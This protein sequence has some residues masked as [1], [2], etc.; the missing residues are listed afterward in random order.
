M[1]EI[2]KEEFDAYEAVRESG[3]TN[4][5]LISRVSDLS[6]LDKEIIKAIMK[7][8]GKLIEKYPSE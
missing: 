6:G 1:N 4:M 5:F 3:V 7:N 2:T 8:Y